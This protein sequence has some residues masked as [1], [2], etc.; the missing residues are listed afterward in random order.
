MVGIFVLAMLMKELQ[1]LAV[2][3]LEAVL[4]VVIVGM[5][6]MVVELE[7]MMGSK[8]ILCSS[9]HGSVAMASF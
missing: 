3:V 7:G 1:A 6:V 8:Q 5:V 9:V 2:V 4:V